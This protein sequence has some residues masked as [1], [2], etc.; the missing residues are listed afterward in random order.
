MNL[1]SKTPPFAGLS[2]ARSAG[3]ERQ[4]GTQGD[5]TALLSAIEHF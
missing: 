1:K 5:K 2:L 4:G 3:L